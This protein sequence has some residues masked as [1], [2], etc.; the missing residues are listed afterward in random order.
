MLKIVQTFWNSKNNENPVLNSGGFV[1]PEIHWMAWAL[2][3]LQLR[4]FYPDVELHTNQLGK[5]ILVDILGLPYTQVH[6]SLENDFMQNLHPKMWAYA[7]IHTYSKQTEPFLHVDGDVFIWKAFDEKLLSSGL[8]AQN[9]EDNLDVYHQCLKSIKENHN[10]LV[11]EWVKHNENHPKAY[12]AGILGGHNLNFLKKYTNL[13]FEFYNNNK[14]EELEKL[15]KNINILPEQYLFYALA[16]QFEEEVALY[17]SKKI[18]RPQDFMD[19]VNIGSVPLEV[20]YIH[21]LSTTKKMEHIC[22]FISYVLKKEHPEYWHKI[23]SYFQENE[24][25]SEYFKRQIIIDRGEIHIP[26]NFE[27]DA[28]TFKQSREIAK[29]LKLDYKSESDNLI[30]KDVYSFEKEIFEFR[31][32]N[33]IKHNFK[34]TP[35][36]TYEKDI[37]PFYKKNFKDYCVFVTPH[38][39]IFTSK[40]NWDSGNVYVSDKLNVINKLDNSINLIFSDL[41]YYSTHRISLNDTLL[42]ILETLKE[43]PRNIK[44][45]INEFS[46]TINED[47]F[48]N[49]LK[50]WMAYGL[51]FML[52]V[53]D[54]IIK[55][56]PS[57]VFLAFNENFRKQISSCIHFILKH[58]HLENYNSKVV[59]QFDNDLRNVSVGEV[60]KQLEKLNFEAKGVKG[61]ISSFLKIPLP[62]ITLVSF[63]NYSKFYIVIFK[64]EKDIVTIFNTSNNTVED[65]QLDYFTT[66]WDGIL[67]LMLPKTK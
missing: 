41:Y 15:D 59:H 1:C 43:K 52:P 32:R 2:S 44:E 9:I 46:N 5:E 62:C 45:L 26:S 47:V 31:S 65:Y 4:K 20:S 39:K 63:P 57:S 10:I 67:I 38:H 18:T 6:L 61:D 25:V 16:S 33:F 24:L 53:K 58:Y 8:I 17:T 56:E 7:K 27:T 30:L 60:I 50:I 55:Q 11:P 66:I 3:C 12:N 36:S 51:I 21:T 23:I 64:V 35:W 48:I 40:F 49:L 28:E 22:N 19:F 34:I 14:L 42:Y 54:K 29:I 13:A 37:N